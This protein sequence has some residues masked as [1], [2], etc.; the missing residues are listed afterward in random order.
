VEI[1]ARGHRLCLPRIHWYT[2]FGKEYK[3]ALSI[4]RGNSLPNCELTFGE[5]DSVLLRII[6]D[7]PALL[8]RPNNKENLIIN[9]L[10]KE[11]FWNEEDDWRNPN[12]K[13]K[14]PDYNFEQE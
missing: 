8:I 1:E 10:D 3:E 11:Y 12:F 6:E 7:N 4:T 14:M 5:N 9:S 2:Y 13:Y